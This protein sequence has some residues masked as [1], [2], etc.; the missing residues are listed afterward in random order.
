MKLKKNTTNDTNE[1]LKKHLQGSKE[2]YDD[3]LNN[4]LSNYKF[5]DEEYNTY[6]K[7][8]EKIKGLEQYQRDILF[9]YSQYG[10]TK[11]AKLLQVSRGLINKTIQ[12]IRSYVKD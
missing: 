9:L 4:T 5:T 2:I 3:V 8:F 12:K 6:S 7:A 1:E 10:A 11:T